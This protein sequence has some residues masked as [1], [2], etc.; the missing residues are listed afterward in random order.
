[1][2][3][4]LVAGARPNFMK[5]AALSRSLLKNNIDYVLVHTGQHY[6]KNMSDIFFEEFGLKKPDW[7]L[8][9]KSGNHADQ[10]AEIMKKFNKVCDV[11]KPDIVVVIGDINSTIACALVVS[12]LSNV[13][14]AHVES[15]ERSFDRSMPEEINRIVTDVVSDYLFCATKKS[16]LNLL[17]EGVDENK[18]FLVGNVMID[19]LIYYL[20]KIERC[21][22]GGDILVTIHRASNTDN[23]VNLEIILSALS[24]ISKKASVIFPLH[25]RTMKKI[26]EF[27]LNFYL[28]NISVVDPYS[29][30]EFVRVMRESSL[31]V[32]D[33]GG[34]QVETTVLNV[35]CITVREN[36]EWGFTLTEG[37]N[38]LV[39]VNKDKI[40][41]NVFKVLNGDRKY[42]NLTTENQMLLDGKSSNRIVEI[43]KKG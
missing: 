2:K 39:G 8:A 24:E 15:G 37:T 32:T 19:N 23:K 14:L 31:V 36:T 28:N 42:K 12:K 20:S 3:I 40:I 16:K 4:I 41:E 26:R 5:L 7:N 17:N 29:Y 10:T 38:T 11:E 21:E 27:G 25:P 33:S 30:F 35:P 18:I 13:C 9:V 1:M 6:D 22:I 43:L 34:I